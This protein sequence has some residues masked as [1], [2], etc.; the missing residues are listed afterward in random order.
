MS[1]L[2]ARKEQKLIE[3]SKKD[4]NNFT[5]LYKCFVREVYRYVYVFVKDR[6]KAED[7]V[8]Q[9]FLIA[10]EKLKEFEWKGI[11]IKY[12]LLRIARNLAYRE[13]KID[14]TTTLDDEED[15]KDIYEEPIEEK[16]VSEEIQRI[17]KELVFQ[18]DEITREVM[19]LR[20][21][22]DMKFKEIAEVTEM[23]ES[24]VKMRF[25]RGIEKLKEIYEK[26]YKSKKMLAIDIALIFLGI[27]A[28]TGSAEFLPTKAFESSLLS[29][30]KDKTILIIKK[31]KMAKTIGET[32][33]QSHEKD[34]VH[35]VKQTGAA[36]TKVGGIKLV[37]VAL[38]AGA[39]L[40]IGG[41][42]GGIYLINKDG[43]KEEAD[44]GDKAATTEDVV[45]NEQ[46][47]TTTTTTEEAQ[48]EESYDGWKAVNFKGY[49]FY[50][51]EDW[52][53]KI[54]DKT[55][56]D[57][58]LDNTYLFFHRGEIQLWPMLYA[59]TH[60]TTY[61]GNQLESILPTEEILCETLPVD[62]ETDYFT[63]KRFTRT[64]DGDFVT[65]TFYNYVVYDGSAGLTLHI[66]FRIDKDDAELLNLSEELVAKVR[67][68]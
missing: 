17:L 67:P 4:L 19:I 8:S 34:L 58:P 31:T 35:K 11:S 54:T 1:K 60:I 42:L 55:E 43:K 12:W 38:A 30:I 63:F 6:H 68:E 59:E 22:E 10:L 37:Y 52:K 57:T 23:K 28:F 48:V 9:T 64:C 21:W 39:I 47:E 5:E 14:P 7:I 45:T 50:Y 53:V 13:L 33:L 41:V 24:A 29:K 49:I 3:D 25:L 27:K 66:E 15:A 44:G 36:V 61:V 62:Y 65:S 40:I 26:K 32:G 51:P 18:L 16:V 46:V 56:E 2:T 20:I